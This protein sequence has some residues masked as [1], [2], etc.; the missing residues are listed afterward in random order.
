MTLKPIK[1]ATMANGKKTLFESVTCTRCGGSGLYGPTC[2]ISGRCFK[3]GGQGVTLTKRGQVA[4][5]FYRES[6]RKRGAEVVVGDSIRDDGVPGM[7]VGLGWCE[8]TEVEKKAD[9][10]YT[11]HALSRR[12]VAYHENVTADGT[13]RVARTGQE[14]ADRIAAA[15]A[16]QDTLTKSGTVRKDKAMVA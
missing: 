5:T 12:G 11:V 9:G 6:L 1:S 3:C 4:T 14:K 13:I 10:S 8:V 15:K 7:I 16:Y 2:V